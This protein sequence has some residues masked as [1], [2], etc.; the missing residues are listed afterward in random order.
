[1]DDKAHGHDNDHDEAADEQ[2]VTLD[3]LPFIQSHDEFHLL[4]CH[5]HFSSIDKLHDDN[6]DDHDQNNGRPVIR[7]EIGKRQVRRG[8]DHDIRRVT[9][10]CRRAADIG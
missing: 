3:G 4:R 7:D 9:D 10:Q 6:G 2:I 1:M 5:M 8:T